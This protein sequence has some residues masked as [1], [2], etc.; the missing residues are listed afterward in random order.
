MPGPGRRRS[1][2]WPPRWPAA[3][4]TWRRAATG[5]GPARRLAALPGLGPWTV[6]SIA[7]RG[8]GDPDAFLPGDLGVRLAARALGLPATPAA[9]TGGRPPGGP[10]GPTPSST[11][12][13]PATTPS[14]ASR[15]PDWRRATA[16][17]RADEQ[18]RT[19]VT[20]TD[21][22]ARRYRQAVVASPIGPLTLVESGGA[23]AGLYMDEHKHL[24]RPGGWPAGPPGAE[25][26]PGRA[27][28]HGPAAG[29]VLRRRADRVRPAAGPG[30]HA[31]SS[32][33]S[34]P[35]CRTS[36]TARR[37]PTASWPAGSARSPPRPARS[38]WPTAATRCRSSCP[39]T[40]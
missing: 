22:T 14:T 17:T 32:S 20:A 1:P 31:P 11:C 29:R 38:A 39:A 9:L 28:R 30:G 10:G 35:A 24:P 15:P 12:G 8:L 26:P 21:D 36:R 19:P 34:G 25:P 16:I 18:E 7:M 27:G 4:S 33:G 2:R 6:E 5:P 23:L 13:P 37:S 3:S 40:G